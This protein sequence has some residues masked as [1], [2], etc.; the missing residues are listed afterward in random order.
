LDSKIYDFLIIGA[1]SAGCS[2]AYFLRKSGKKVAIIDREGI[3]GGASG[4]AGAFLSPLPGKQNLY[5]T[6]VNDALN[7]SIDFYEKLIARWN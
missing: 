7:F 6:F 3:A 2:T 1:G 4:V 5:N